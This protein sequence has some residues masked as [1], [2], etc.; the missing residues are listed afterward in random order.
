[1]KV[2]VGQVATAYTTLS[3]I[4]TTS[5]ELDEVIDL[6]DNRSAMR[7]TYNAYKA[8]H[9]DAMETCKPADFDQL[10]EIAQKGNDATEEEKMRLY[11]GDFEY[12]RKVDAA[13]KDFFNKEVE[14]EIKPMSNKTFA[15]FVHDN[16]WTPEVLDKIEFLKG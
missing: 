1:M 7:D 3:K 12:Q 15:K 11:Q 13:C 8:H 4:A 14:I 6:I 5:L 16:K 2:T 9:E 10:V